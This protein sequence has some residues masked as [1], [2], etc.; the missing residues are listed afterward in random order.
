[1][2][3]LVFSDSLVFYNPKSLLLK[4]AK[5]SMMRIL[6]FMFE[7]AQDPQK[8]SIRNNLLKGVWNISNPEGLL[9]SKALSYFLHYV[10]LLED[11]RIIDDI[12][13]SLRTSSSTSADVIAFIQQLKQEVNKSLNEIRSSLQANPPSWLRS[14]QGRVDP[15]AIDKALTFASQ[16]WLFTR[17]DLANGNQT[18]ANAVKARLDKNPRSSQ[19]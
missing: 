14:V 18:L 7:A 5:R 10:R 13:I 9:E 12:S 6:Q 17:L 2:I 1:M 16:L 19:E 4:A 8:L 11:P 3:L 15:S